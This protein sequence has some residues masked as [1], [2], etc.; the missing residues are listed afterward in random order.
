[1]AAPPEKTIK[2]LNGVW[3]MVMQSPHLYVSH[4]DHYPE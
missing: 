3:V 2:D 4:A 1:M